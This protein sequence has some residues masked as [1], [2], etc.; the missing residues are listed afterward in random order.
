MM[1]VYRVTDKQ[2]RGSLFLTRELAEKDA[3]FMRIIEPKEK[4]EVHCLQVHDALSF[5]Y[6]GFK[7]SQGKTH[8]R[9]QHTLRPRRRR[10]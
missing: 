1:F 2:G 10:S 8:A 6:E 4:F 3:E 9:Q 7:K 5:N